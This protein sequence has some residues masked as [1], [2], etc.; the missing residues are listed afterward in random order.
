M[1]HYQEQIPLYLAGQLTPA[2]ASSLEAH[3]RACPLCQEELAYWRDLAAEIKTSNAAITP[4]SSLVDRALERIHQQE[5]LPRSSFI[6]EK[7]LLPIQRTAALLRA[8]A[9]LVK[10]ELW[11][12]AAAIMALGV[13]TS[14]ISNHA[15]VIQF[16][17]PMIAAASLA[18]LYGPENDPAHELVLAAPTSPWKILLARLSV[19]SAYNLL[20]ALLASLAL[21]WI[22]PP[23]LLAILILGWLAP[24]AF[25]SALALLLSVWIGSGNALVVA[26][27][28]WVIQFLKI[29]IVAGNWAYYPGL[30]AFLTA[31]RSF[32]QSPA[33]L[34]PF[35]LALLIISLLSTRITERGL[36]APSV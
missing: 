8:Q 35:S 24:L 15:E 22:V 3:L 1:K 7:I 4:P 19:V 34:L 30:D 13:I 33:L 18:S 14:L 23:D 31:Y 32:W 11:P 20:L 12:T 5:P 21:L 6:S 27:G 25:L 26:Y 17:A 2:Q 16:L 9:Y 28:L 36:N 29:S 10:R